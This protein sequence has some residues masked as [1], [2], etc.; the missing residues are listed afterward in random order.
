MMELMISFLLSANVLSA[1]DFHEGVCLRSEE[2]IIQL[3][4]EV[5][6]Q[7]A[8]LKESYAGG[9]GLVVITIWPVA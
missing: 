4:D 7:E 6:A 1:G 5:P 3:L 9:G 8:E 2:E